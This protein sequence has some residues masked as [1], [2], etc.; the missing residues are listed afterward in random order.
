MNNDM[1]ALASRRLR[2]SDRLNFGHKANPLVPYLKVLLPQAG[3]GVGKSGV[4]TIPGIRAIGA[5]PTAYG[6]LRGDF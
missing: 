2:T 1:R 5:T 3:K 6:D 4:L